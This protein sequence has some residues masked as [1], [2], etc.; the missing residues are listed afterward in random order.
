[1]L[2]AEIVHVPHCPLDELPVCMS[3]ACRGRLEINN[4]ILPSMGHSIAISRTFAQADSPDRS[5]DSLG[6]GLRETQQSVEVYGSGESNYYYQVSRR[7]SPAAAATARAGLQQD[8]QTLCLF[9]NA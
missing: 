2:H 4:F 7:D 6:D 3:P 8:Q 9:S 1:M 5:A